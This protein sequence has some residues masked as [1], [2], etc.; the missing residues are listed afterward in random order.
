MNCQRTDV[1]VFQ[2][3]EVSRLRIGYALLP[4]VTL[5][6]LGCSMEEPRFQ[7]LR[8]QFVLP[9]EPTALTTIADARAQLAENPY[10]QLIGRIDTDEYRAFTRGKAAFLVTEIIADEHGHGGSDHADNCPFC[11][12]KAAET[13]QASVQFVDESGDALNVDARKLFGLQPG[14]RVVIRGT[15]ELVAGLN[16]LVVTADG[17]FLPPRD[18]Q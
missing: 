18:V 10:V 8:Q 12:R 16:L 6:L 7:A 3:R 14:D 2:I 15:G 17:I 11:K 4:V 1:S 9:T 13:P 5:C